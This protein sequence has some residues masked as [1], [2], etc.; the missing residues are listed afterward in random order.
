MTRR[1][2]P[3]G[4]ESD[5]KDD[6]ELIEEDGFEVGEHAYR[7]PVKNDG[8][9]KT[10]NTVKV[11]PASLKIK[12]E[13]M[14]EGEKS[15]ENKC[16]DKEIL[17]QIVDKINKIEDGM[18]RIQQNNIHKLNCFSCGEQG[19]FSRECPYKHTTLGIDG[20][21]SNLRNGEPTLQGKSV[22]NPT[23]CNYEALNEIGLAPRA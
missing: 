5:L 11:G 2:T 10:Q 20:L 16:Q 17:Q 7:V 19:H 18:R 22:S 21:M 15:S 4:V 1:T 3:L 14:T 6:S 13:D 8:V 9:K 23:D 12:K